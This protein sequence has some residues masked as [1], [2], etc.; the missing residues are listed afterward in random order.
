MNGVK[1]TAPE[2]ATLSRLGSGDSVV[3]SQ[4]GDDGW[5]TD[6][7][8]A[9]VGNEIISLRKK[10]LI[11]R[12]CDDEENYRGMSERDVISAAG[13]LALSSKPTGGE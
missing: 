9:F 1:L 12:V 6:G 10:G 2:C 7:D 3:Y 13:R 4:D 11:E 8:R 5:F